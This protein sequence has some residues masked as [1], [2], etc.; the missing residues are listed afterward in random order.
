MKT[1]FKVAML[2]LVISST[3]AIAEGC[4]L[5]DNPET[6]VQDR[7]IPSQ[8]Q[9]WNACIDK[10]LAALERKNPNYSF[11]DGQAVGDQCLSSQIICES[12]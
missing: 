11:D 5:K 12:I 10:N 3:H 6:V 8:K 2:T 7:S 9:L 4:F 1:L